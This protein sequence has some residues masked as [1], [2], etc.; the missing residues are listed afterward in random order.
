MKDAARLGAYFAATVLFGALAAPPLYWLAQW[1]ISRGFLGFLQGHDFET[2]FHRALLVGA[3]AFLWPLIR[4]LGVRSWRDLGLERNPN[5]GRDAGTGLVI[6]AVPLLC[7]GGLLLGMGVYALRSSVSVAAILERAVS[8][9]VVPFIEEPLFR[10]LILGIL[11]RAGSPLTA[12]LGTSA[13]FSI[14]HFLKA[15]EGTSAQV[16]W[17]SGFRSIGNSFG[18]FHEPL[19]VAAAFTTLFVLGWILADARLRTRSLW[20][21]IGLHA[22]W[23]FS[24][25]LFNKLA[26]RELELLPWIGRNLLV[27]LAPLAVALLSWA[28]MRAWLR[29]ARPAKN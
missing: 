10:G 21:P 15:P 5:R 11:L 14:V 20:L 13:L 3:V 22:G 7:F 29:Y 24:S 8:A 18:Q 4:S 16:T 19:L 1:L 23:I 25:A 6:A 17:S 12:A 9:A 26:S 27:G 28:M 2:F